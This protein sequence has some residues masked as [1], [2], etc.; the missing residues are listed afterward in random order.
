MSAAASASGE[1]PHE[2][3]SLRTGICIESTNSRVQSFASLTL[4]ALVALGIWQMW[5]LRSFF[6]RKY[7]ID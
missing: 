7:L 6:Q 4:V 1:W 3:D 5:H 2:S